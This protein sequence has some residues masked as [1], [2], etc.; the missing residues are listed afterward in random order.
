M[1]KKKKNTSRKTKYQKKSFMFIYVVGKWEWR[2]NM[3][4]PMKRKKTD[5]WNDNCK[6]MLTT[7]E[8]KAS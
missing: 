7:F 1:A 6:T 8:S 5:M 4:T 3:N 2:K